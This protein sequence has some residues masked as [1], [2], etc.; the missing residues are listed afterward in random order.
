M[1]PYY[2]VGQWLNWQSSGLQN[3]RLGVRVPPGLPSSFQK[4][5]SSNYKH[6]LIFNTE[7]LNREC[8]KVTSEGSKLDG[9]KWLS[10]S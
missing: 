2:A 9:L 1:P 4:L 5:A 6:F 7:A 3:R 8:S 10:C